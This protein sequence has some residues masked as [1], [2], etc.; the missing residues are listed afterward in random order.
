[1]PAIC[2]R[3]PAIAFRPPAAMFAGDSSAAAAPMPISSPCTKVCTVDLRSGLC[4]GC[5]RTLDEIAR[6]PSL[7]EGE[8]QR[9]M[10]ELADRHLRRRADVR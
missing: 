10:S 6:W 4:V 7:T 8:R 1:M 3:C 5:G 9:L 2:A